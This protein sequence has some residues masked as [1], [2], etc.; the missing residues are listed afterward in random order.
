MRIK[1][2]IAILAAVAAALNWSATLT[3]DETPPPTVGK[4]AEDI[5]NEARERVEGKS[6]SRPDSREREQQ[7]QQPRSFYVAI[8]GETMTHASL[9]EVDRTLVAQR[10]RT[11]LQFLESRRDYPLD[12]SGDISLALGYELTSWLDVE[13]AAHAMDAFWQGGGSGAVHDSTLS[14]AVKSTDARQFYRLDASAYS[15]SLLPRWDINDFVGI[16]GRVGVGY[17]NTMLLS[18]L[19]SA[20]FVS[21]SQSCSVENGQ[22]MCTTTYNYERRQWDYIHQTRSGFFPVAAIGVQLVPFFRLEYIYRADV[23][24]GESTIDVSAIYFSFLMKSAW[25]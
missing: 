18:D 5:I 14:D 10:E 21:S 13:L 2:N 9:E 19:S 8:G 1:R 11:A 25:F 17:A 6:G 22:E 24:A 16:F 15:L 4:S 12:Q 3:A 7:K 20:G 23:P